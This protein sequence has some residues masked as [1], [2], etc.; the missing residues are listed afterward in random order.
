MPSRKKAPRTSA[1]RRRSVSKK[2]TAVAAADPLPPPIVDIPASEVG[3]IVQGLINDRVK[4]LEVG[5][6][7]NALFTITLLQ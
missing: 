4:K 5:E 7:T 2:R 3:R 1:S 6:Q